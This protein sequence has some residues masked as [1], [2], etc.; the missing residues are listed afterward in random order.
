M[1]ILHAV[2]N[3]KVQFFNKKDRKAKERARFIVGIISSHIFSKMTLQDK[4][5]SIAK[6]ILIF[7]CDFGFVPEKLERTLV[8]LNQKLNIEVLRTWTEFYSR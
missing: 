6:L 3:L 1:N 8:R 2:W 7:E 4:I 5:S